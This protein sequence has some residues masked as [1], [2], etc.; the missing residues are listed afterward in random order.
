MLPTDEFA[1]Q[2]N[3]NYQIFLKNRNDANST[4]GHW[5]PNLVKRSLKSI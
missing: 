1:L 3:I 2:K 5:C 4:E